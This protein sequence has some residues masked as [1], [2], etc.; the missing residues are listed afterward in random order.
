MKLD[1]H[2]RRHLRSPRP[3]VSTEPY[4][5]PL[6]EADDFGG[7]RTMPPIL[8]SGLTT[9]AQPPYRVVH[10]FE[11]ELWYTHV[12]GNAKLNASHGQRF[13][14]DDHGRVVPVV[15]PQ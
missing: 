9:T 13:A 14:F 1:L 6:I 4:Y 8:I 2:W 7:E 5:P 12:R 3:H 15:D 11:D 10:D